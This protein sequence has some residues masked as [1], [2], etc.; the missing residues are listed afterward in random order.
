MPKL[1]QSKH[2]RFTRLTAELFRQPTFYLIFPDQEAEDP[3]APEEDP[4]AYTGEEDVD[5]L[6]AHMD[7]EAEEEEV[8]ELQPAQLPDEP[9]PQRVELTYEQMRARDY[10]TDGETKNALKKLFHRQ[11]RE[12]RFTGIYTPLHV[13]RL[14][15]PNSV[16][17]EVHSDIFEDV[18]GLRQMPVTV[19][20]KQLRQRPRRLT[21]MG[22][23]AHYRHA[24]GVLLDYTAMNQ[25][26]KAAVPE[27]LKAL[28]EA[29]A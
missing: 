13:T 22:S 2:R 18:V 26:K 10:P 11:R 16:S 9:E 1:R 25:E 20:N 21:K 3:S 6:L 8:E 7:E 29:E 4:H 23:T 24:T 15:V 12:R 27:W 17:L 19:L 14:W 5:A 28:R